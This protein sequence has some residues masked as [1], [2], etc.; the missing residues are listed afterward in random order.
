VN[1]AHRIHEMITPMRLEREAPSPC[2]RRLVSG[3]PCVDALDEIVDDVQDVIIDVTDNGGVVRV[4]R[5]RIEDLPVV[6]LR[7]TGPLGGETRALPCAPP[8]RDL[9]R[10]R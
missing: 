10:P 2:C 9:R 5:R 8:R 4:E 7:D 1:G 6:L 3:V